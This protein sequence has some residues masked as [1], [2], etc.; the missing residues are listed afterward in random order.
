MRMRLGLLTSTLILGACAAAA[1]AEEGRSG[2]PRFQPCIW[3]NP[4]GAKGSASVQPP[5]AQPKPDPKPEK[6]KTSPAAGD[7]AKTAREEHAMRANRSDP[8]QD[9]ILEDRLRSEGGIV[10]A[11]RIRENGVE[12][13]IYQGAG[14]QGAV[15]LASLDRS[16]G[17]PESALRTKDGRFEIC[18]WPKKC[19]VKGP[20]GAKGKV[21]SEGQA[22]K[23]LNSMPE[24]P[25]DRMWEAAK[26]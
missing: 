13:I 16:M 22:A 11:M 6:E 19:G 12:R 21:D 17:L 24:K 8:L 4:C 10:S 18:R 23:E 15:S 2:S 5:P 14:L 1:M 20:G 9:K 7:A 3:P 25:A 26:R